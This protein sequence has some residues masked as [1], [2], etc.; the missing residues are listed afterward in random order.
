M[1]VKNHVTGIAALA[2]AWVITL[3]SWGVFQVCC[4]WTTRLVNAEQVV[5][6]LEEERLC[7]A[8]I[9]NL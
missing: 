9:I 1:G 3:F 6:H 8:R 7:F 4:L 5:N 2:I